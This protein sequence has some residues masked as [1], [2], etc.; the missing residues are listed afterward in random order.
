MTTTAS[1]RLDAAALP[2][3]AARSGGSAAVDAHAS[4]VRRVLVTG[5]AGF[6]GSR[7]AAVLADD[8]LQ[9]VGCDNLN[10]Y[11]D[12]ALKLARVRHFLAP[13]RIAFLPLD[14]R[15]GAAL[16]RLVEQHRFDVVVHLAAKAGV[17][18]AANAP[19]SYLQDN[20]VVF[21]HVLE[22]CRHQAVRHL[23][24]G[25]SSSVYGRRTQ[26]PF[27]EDDDTDHPSSLYAAT[28]R[29]NELM[30]HAYAQRFGVA[31]TGLRF[32]TVYGPWG[33]PDMAYYGFAERLLQGRPIPLYG[34]G[35]PQ[36][37]FTAIDDVAEA[38]R[39]LVLAP[40]PTGDAP[41]PH[42]VCNVGNRHPVTM[43]EFVRT[44]ETVFGIEAIVEPLPLPAD[45]VPV[46]CADTQRL[47]DWT[48][49]EPDTPLAVGL[50]RF[51]DWYRSWRDRRATTASPAVATLRSA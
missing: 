51:A 24:Y 39:R 48:G 29:A 19:E 27:R 18:H 47:R 14:L 28:K 37:D 40:C 45:D 11:Y 2:D 15:D 20:L 17:R 22:A 30:A 38:L 35:A 23:V 41:V 32:F 42:G 3:S 49:F 8:G 1:D 5:A 43:R 25:S 6:I 46:T 12:P 9:V 4:T 10:P 16:M 7:V 21:G 33:R 26:V 34:G 50:G 44:M 36:R 13:R 31:A